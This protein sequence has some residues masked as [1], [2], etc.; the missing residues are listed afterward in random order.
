[1]GWFIFILFLIGL[2]IIIKY[3]SSSKTNKKSKAPATQL[4]I[5]IK[6][7]I[8]V[9]A[10]LVSDI[11]DSPDTGQLSPSPDGGWIL[12]PSTSFSLTMTGLTR[13]KAL[14][15]KKILDEGFS[16]GGYMVSQ[17]LFPIITTTNLKCKE[18]TDYIDKYRPLFLSELN[19]RL[20]NYPDWDKM[21]A[22]DK[23][24]LLA[25]LR[26]KAIQQIDVLPDCNVDILFLSDS[27]DHALDDILLARYGYEALSFYLSKKVKVYTIPADHYERKDFENMAIAGL[28]IRGEQIPISSI[29]ETLTIKDMTALVADTNPP[30][31]SRKSKGIEY[32][33]SIPDIKDRIKKQLSMRSLF[34]I[35]PLPAE[36]SHIDL[37]KIQQSWAFAGELSRLITTTYY[38]AGY[39]KRSR[40]DA[41]ENISSWEV[42]SNDDCCPSCKRLSGK[43]YRTRPHTPFHIG[44]RCR[45]SPVFE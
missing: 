32:L 37:D 14:E 24:D 1:V 44:C 15:I 28:A 21:S 5:D 31:F 9:T 35:Q 30:K 26:A 41:L 4:D 17:K 33:L 3:S 6:P 43:R 18:V 45:I 39:D 34:K 7:E 10:S 11:S 42:Y 8:K 23:E 40:T 13:E 27:V 22:L 20:G 25:E 19:R 2:W 36:Y 29:I 38:A 16:N 12:N